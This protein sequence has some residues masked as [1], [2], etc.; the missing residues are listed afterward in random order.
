M[1]ERHL[2]QWDQ[3]KRS[4]MT[5]PV[6]RRKKPKNRP[7]RRYPLYVDFDE[8]GISD[9]IQAPQG[10]NA[11]YCHGSCPLLSMNV[12][13]HTLL[14][15]VVNSINQ[16]AMPKTCCVPTKLRAQTLLVLEEEDKLVAT[17]YPD[18]IVEE[19]GCR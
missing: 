16:A 18:M 19:C 14:Q 15:T 17:M 3:S 4:M 12:S 10:Y 9:W 5:K 2:E 1:M 6:K 7:C 13:T 11:Y 8:I